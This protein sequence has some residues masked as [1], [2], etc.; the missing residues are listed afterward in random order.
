MYTQYI[1]YILYRI[2]LILYRVYYTGYIYR[3]FIPDIPDIYTG[4][5]KKD[6]CNVYIKIGV[7]KS[8]NIGVYPNSSPR[9]QK[10]RPDTTPNGKQ[11]KRK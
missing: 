8:M 2:Y 6:I 9:T 7:N 4:E 10:Y 5:T 1:S 3:I 11:H